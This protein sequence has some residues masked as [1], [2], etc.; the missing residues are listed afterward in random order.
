MES[1]FRYHRRAFHCRER[2]QRLF[3]AH[4]A[5]QLSLI[6]LALYK[7]F[8]SSAVSALTV[9]E[10]ARQPRWNASSGGICRWTEDTLAVYSHPAL[11]GRSNISDYAG[12]ISSTFY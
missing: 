1:A 12:S 4:V 11:P 7:R 6:A 10:M 3:Q 5:S 2:W 9:A 8:Q